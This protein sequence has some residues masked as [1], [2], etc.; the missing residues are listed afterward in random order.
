MVGMEEKTKVIS[1]KN[2]GNSNREVARQIGLN[3]ETVDFLHN[4]K[5]RKA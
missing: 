5:E 1:L 2:E 4:L 3:R